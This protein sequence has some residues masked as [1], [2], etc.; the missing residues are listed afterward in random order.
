MPKSTKKIDFTGRKFGPF[1][2]TTLLRPETIL[3]YEV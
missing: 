2:V 3:E 1:T